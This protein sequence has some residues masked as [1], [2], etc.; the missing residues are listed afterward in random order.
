VFAIE[1]ETCARCHG[2]QRVMANIE[3]REVI[4]RKLA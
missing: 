4:T 1:N 3:D 2:R